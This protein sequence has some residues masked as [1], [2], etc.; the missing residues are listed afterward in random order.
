MP[1]VPVAIRQTLRGV[2]AHT[3]NADGSYNRCI[4][5]SEDSHGDVI[6][7]ASLLSGLGYGRQY[8]L[9]LMGVHSSVSTSPVQVA[10]VANTM[11]SRWDVIPFDCLVCM[12]KFNHI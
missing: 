2:T 10:G 12:P 9:D 5:N 4:V 7:T 3:L 11:G 6:L 8:R 1:A